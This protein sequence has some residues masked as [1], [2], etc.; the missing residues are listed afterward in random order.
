VKMGKLAVVVALLGGM[1][2]SG[3]A[4]AAVIYDNGVVD[5]TS[6]ARG[7]DE[8]ETPGPGPR[9][10]A[11][12]FVLQ[13]GGNVVH[14]VHWWGTYYPDSPLP[15]DNFT[16]YIYDDANGLPGVLI[17]NGAINLGAAVNRTDTGFNL[18][19]P[20]DINY[21]VYSYDAVFSANITLDAGKLYWLS[22]V[23]NVQPSGWAW[24]LEF[25]SGNGA[26]STNSGASWETMAD[27]YA[28]RLTGDLSAVPEPAT[29]ALL[30]LG[31]AGLGFSRRRS[32]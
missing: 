26:T 11:D 16:I 1:G 17:S 31:L 3:L 29:L 18:S 13:A 28:F 9:R 7:S 14:D 19:V 25:A 8:L 20:G 4:G 21:D 2:L 5:L 10:N 32:H 27:K 23:N 22:V 15:T 12:D 30:G 24:S 6:G